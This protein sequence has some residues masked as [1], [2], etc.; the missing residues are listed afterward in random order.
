MVAILERLAS[1]VERGLAVPVLLLVRRSPSRAAIERDV[2]R[3]VEVLE[4]PTSW[5]FSRQVGHLLRRY[6][7][8][9]NLLQFRLS[10]DPNGT[11]LR[12]LTFRLWRPVK[13]LI[14]DI[15][16]LGPGLFIQHG[17]ATIVS[18]QRLGE[19]C[20]INQQVTIGHVYDRGSPII[21]DRVTIAAG[22]VV[23]GPVVIGDDVT[24]GA[25][26]TVVKDVPSGSVVVGQPSRIVKR[27]S[28]AGGDI[29]LDDLSEPAGG[30][31][32]ADP[33]AA[34]GHSAPSTTAATGA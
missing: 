28:R 20:W 6:P 31:T 15:G 23:V 29:D 26:T 2:E 25:N 14:L 5:R 22:A 18:A 32:G 30:G 11:L 4:I 9:R 21:G 24:I 33:T 8:F 3:W 16:E 7:E 1:L 34:D 13:T 12:A 10:R 27:Y 19:D 17:F